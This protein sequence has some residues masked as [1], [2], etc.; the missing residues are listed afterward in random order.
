MARYVVLGRT[1]GLKAAY[2][3][4]APK[5]NGLYDV[6]EVDRVNRTVERRGLAAFEVLA[7]PRPG[8]LWLATYDLDPASRS[9]YDYKRIREELALRHA[10]GRADNSTY[11]CASDPSDTLR[12]LVEGKGRYR[13]E[14]VRPANGAAEA[15]ARA[16]MVD[17]L[18]FSAALLREQAS[19]LRGGGVARARRML[20]AARA[21]VESGAVDL[22]ASLAGRD[23]ARELSEAYAALGAS[24]G[25]L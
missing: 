25:L 9:S 2:F 5:Y 8:C 4:A 16:A 13:V 19:R 18:T 7:A 20:E 6:Y 11:L 3:N 15:L 17:A 21:A 24:L 22:A 1:A 10:C 14:C 12:S 23:L